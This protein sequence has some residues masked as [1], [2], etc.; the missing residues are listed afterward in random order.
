MVAARFADPI[1][2]LQPYQFARDRDEDEDLEEEPFDPK[3][4]PEP[5]NTLD[6]FEWQRSISELIEWS[7]DYAAYQRKGP[8]LVETDDDETR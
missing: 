5:P 4:P 6:F 7:L 3:K 1:V 2:S 8:Q